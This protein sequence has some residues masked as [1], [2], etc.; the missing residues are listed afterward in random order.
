MHR[1]SVTAGGG[2]TSTKMMA[3]TPPNANGNTGH[4]TR[5]AGNGSLPR[6]QPN[7]NTRAHV[8]RRT[9]G[10]GGGSGGPN[11]GDRRIQNLVGP[12]GSLGQKHATT[13]IG[14]GWQRDH[15]AREGADKERTEEEWAAL[16][17]Q[18]ALR[19]EEGRAK[20]AVEFGGPQG[21]MK[22]DNAVLAQDLG[23]LVEG[24]LPLPREK[25]SME[26]CLEAVRGTILDAKRTLEKC[27]FEAW[28]EESTCSGLGIVLGRPGID[29]FGSAANGLGVRSGNDI[30][31]TVVFDELLSLSDEPPPEEE[32]EEE[33]HEEHEGG[34]GGE[35]TS[36]KH[37]KHAHDEKNSATGSTE[38]STTAN[39]KDDG[40][41]GNGTGS[42]S[43]SGSGT[44]TGTGLRPR[45][46][47][48]RRS[49]CYARVVAVLGE[50]FTQT[51]GVF[52]DIKAVTTARVPVLKMRHV[53]SGVSC[54]VTINNLLALHNTRLLRDYMS[55]DTRARDLCMIVK[56]WAKRRAVNEAYRG[57][58]SSYAYV[59]MCIQ[60][61]QNRPVPILPVLQEFVP[62]AKDSE[63]PPPAKVPVGEWDVYYKPAGEYRD[64]GAANKESLADLL[65]AF[66]YY[67]HVEHNYHELVVTIRKP[68]GCLSKEEKGWKR[69]QG[70]DRV[71]LC[72]E[73]PFELSHNLGRVVDH[74]SLN[75][76]RKEFRV[77][78]GILR[79]VADPLP[80]LLEPFSR[81]HIQRH[82]W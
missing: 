35:A 39:T 6:S 30:D 4:L 5:G 26:V 15:K 31:V 9:G 71:L 68:G 80:R 56:H 8:D 18:A 51:G 81:G 16:A 55:I 78:L 60:L 22:A 63:S 2:V 70:V 73:D 12:A 34:E 72:I 17:E 29:M 46:R 54:D 3:T 36:S 49:E 69:R 79:D 21:P 48:G 38:H 57:T 20:A 19:A 43:G 24:L 23:K 74:A 11:P 64:F 14:H 53:P 45:R 25:S 32:E 10:V 37:T 75:T 47:R 44:G 7:N 62:M 65:R 82:H 1:T 66:F 76:I 52:T 13:R 27:L 67:W 50:V 28:G 41:G 40:G 33:K 61:L 42:G 77:A 59:I 58:L